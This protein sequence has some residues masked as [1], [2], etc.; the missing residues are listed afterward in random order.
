MSPLPPF[1]PPPPQIKKEEVKSESKNAESKNAAAPVGPSLKVPPSWAQASAGGLQ[2][3]PKVQAGNV[4]IRR[5]NGPG[6]EGVRSLRPR[7]P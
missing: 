4:E 5:S 1:P 6:R 7:F 2:P 3:N